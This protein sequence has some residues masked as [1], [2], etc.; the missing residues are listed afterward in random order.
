LMGGGSNN[1]HLMYQIEDTFQD[2]RQSTSKG[3]FHERKNK[4]P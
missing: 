3:E 4:R 1:R 2:T